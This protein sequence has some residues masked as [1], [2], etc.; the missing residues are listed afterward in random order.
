VDP[1]PVHGNFTSIAEIGLEFHP[2]QLAKDGSDLVQVP[3]D[4]GN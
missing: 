1:R 2:S 3:V 4:F